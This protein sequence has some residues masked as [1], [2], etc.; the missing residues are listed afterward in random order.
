MMQLSF[1]LLG[2]FLD[3]IAILF[4][5]MPIYIPIIKGLGFD[6]LWFAILYIVNMQMAF[7]TP[8]YGVNLFYMKAIVPKG[9][10]MGDIYRSVIPFVLLQAAGLAGLMVFPD[11]VL[12]LPRLIFSR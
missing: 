11:L 10:T 9:V 3:D 4:M 6:P 5:C 1:F 8:P 12:W 7:L 2:M